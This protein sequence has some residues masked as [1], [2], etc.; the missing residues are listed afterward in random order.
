MY[1]FKRTTLAI[2]VCILA[3]I[4]YLSGCVNTKNVA[5]PV[6]LSSELHSIVLLLKKDWMY[7]SGTTFFES[8]LDQ[9]SCLY[10]VFES[11][12]RLEPMTAFYNNRIFPASSDSTDDDSLRSTSQRISESMPSELRL[13]HRTSDK[14]ANVNSRWRNDD[15]CYQMAYVDTTEKDRVY[16][17]VAQYSPV[18]HTS[19][20]YTEVTSQG[21]S[22]V[23]IFAT[24]DNTINSIFRTVKR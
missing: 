16:A 2:T 3:T 11:N 12:M 8:S 9:P 19:R 5:P 20:D 1:H 18:L 17:E 6:Q 23:F 7:T 4:G 10:L 24:E 22:V 13:Q 21:E 14:E 15:H